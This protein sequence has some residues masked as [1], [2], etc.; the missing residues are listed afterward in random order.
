MEPNT[1]TTLL[2]RLPI[3]IYFEN[4]VQ[5]AL[6]ILALF[7]LKR[8]KRKSLQI[9]CWLALMGLVT[10][11]IIKNSPLHS[12]V[13]VIHVLE[14]SLIAFGLYLLPALKKDQIALV[15]I[16]IIIDFVADIMVYYFVAKGRY[17]LFI[18]NFYY[19]FFPFFLF[20]FFYKVLIAG[21][22]Y[23]RVYFFAVLSSYLFFICDYLLGSSYKLNYITIE[24]YCLERVILSCLL[25]AKLVCDEKRAT[26]LIKVPLYWVC[27]GII[28]KGLVV[29]LCKGLHPYLVE[30]YIEIYRSKL[31]GQLEPYS[32][33]VLFYCY[34][35]AFFLCGKQHQERLSFSFK[36]L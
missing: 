15:L 21:G 4:Y 14:V 2:L 20:I 13:S 17:S 1:Q 27:V 11:L 36:F 25:I 26:K 19:I 6:L 23:K 30:H 31:M 7:F 22:R 12:Y 3:Q 8:L 18:D 10:D 32:S 28:I 34:F 35:Y 9:L 16:F 5:L 24:I 33:L 29:M